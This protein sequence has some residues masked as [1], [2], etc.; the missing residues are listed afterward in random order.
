MATASSLVSVSPP[1][2]GAQCVLAVVTDPLARLLVVRLLAASG[3]E[4]EILDDD[5][6]RQPSARR[7]LAVLIDLDLSPSAADV[8]ATLA[9]IRARC[10]GP[11]PYLVAMGIGTSVELRGRYMGAGLD[12][13]LSKPLALP[14]LRAVLERARAVQGT[15]T[16]SAPEPGAEPPPAEAERDRER[17]RSEIRAQVRRYIGDDS[18]EL[19]K[20]GI[21]LF[22]SSAA[23]QLQAMRAAV[24]GDPVAP[25][26]LRRAAHSLKGSSRLFGLQKLAALCEQLEQPAATSRERSHPLVQE[27]AAEFAR[28]RELLQSL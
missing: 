4:A 22:L 11:L 23:Q 2:A 26:P 1:V 16:L 19:V 9:R 12:D 6:P 18:P 15:A 25:E 3:Y 7:Y 14:A 8:M 21:T 28:A 24:A 27:L 13:F 5:P 20:Q 10:T 17:A